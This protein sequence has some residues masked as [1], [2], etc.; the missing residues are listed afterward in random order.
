MEQKQREEIIEGLFN[1]DTNP[2]YSEQD[3][4][5]DLMLF[6]KRLNL[7]NHVSRQDSWISMSA[8]Q[9]Y[10]GFP[11]EKVAQF[12]RDPRNHEKELRDLARYLE[13]TSQIYQR[14]VNYLSSIQ[15]I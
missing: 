15:V 14:V 5:R 8:R 9:N 2:D 10:Q 1:W 12:L 4:N 3:Y 6:A 7:N 11:P 13:N